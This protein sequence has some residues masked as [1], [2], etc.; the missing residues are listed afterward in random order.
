MEGSGHHKDQ[1]ISIR[2][3]FSGTSNP[4]E[5][6]VYDEGSWGSGSSAGTGSVKNMAEIRG[7]FSVDPTNRVLR[8]YCGASTINNTVEHS[9]MRVTVGMRDYYRA[10]CDDELTIRVS[11]TVNDWI[12]SIGSADA[13]GGVYS[14]ITDTHGSILPI[15]GD[16]M[17][18]AEGC[19]MLPEYDQ[20][21]FENQLGY[22]RT[23]SQSDENSGTTSMTDFELSFTVTNGAMVAIDTLLSNSSSAGKWLGDGSGRGYL[24]TMA[25]PC[26]TGG[27]GYVT[28]PDFTNKKVEYTVEVIAGNGT[29]LPYGENTPPE[30]E[31]AGTIGPGKNPGDLSL[32]LAGEEGITY[33]VETSTNLTDWTT[34]FYLAGEGGSSEHAIDPSGTN[35]CYYRVTPIKK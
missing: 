31:P 11:Y 7:Q 34:W 24:G 21:P 26:A 19:F 2:C 12:Q 20:L 28:P 23:F 15:V 8:S 17:N 18:I 30:A 9:C 4:Y 22:E 35:A 5:S 32:V 10:T 3:A 13:Y 16:L 25:G 6:N 14:M 29:F 27:N 1:P 33:Q